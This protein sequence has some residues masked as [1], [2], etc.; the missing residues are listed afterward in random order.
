MRILL[1]NYEYK[2]QCGGA[3]LATYNLAKELNAMGH[4]VS[5]LIGWD[6]RF[7]KP[8]LIQGIDTRIVYIQKK[9]MLE[10]SPKGILQFL[11]KGYFKLFVFSRKENYDIIQFFFSVPTGLLKFSLKKNIPYIC[12]LR[13]M[14]VPSDERNNKFS[15]MIRKIEF[16]NKKVVSGAAA[17]TVLSKQQKI[18]FERAYPQLRAK[19]IPNGVS[20]HGIKVKQK[21]AENVRLFC[22]TGRF[23]EFKNIELTMYA[24]QKVHEKYPD[25]RLDIYGDGYL[26]EHFEQ[27]ILEHNMSDYIHLKGYM[28]QKKLFQLMPEYDVF[29]L[30]SIGDSFGQVFTE[31]M[32]CGLPVICAD[33]GGPADIVLDKE[34]G[35]KIKPND[36]EASVEA[37]FY[38]IEHPQQAELFGRNGRARAEKE[39]SMRG[40]ANR[41]LDLYEKCIRTKNIV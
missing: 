17:I 14:D 23:I 4:K 2:P 41:H 31:A 22:L 32:A 24:F 26:R 27:V 6:K 8:E 30:L 13:G 34:T 5:L 7:G 12:S 29:I 16:L 21:Y 18:C 1:V 3:G 9:G 37:V 10:S 19:I 28:E 15:K 38:M 20:F 11:V 39:Y 40:I 35:L 36:L 25:V 33:I